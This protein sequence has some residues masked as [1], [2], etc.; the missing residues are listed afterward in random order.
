MFETVKNAQSFFVILN[1]VRGTAAPPPRPRRG[2]G[3][4]RAVA[5]AAAAAAAMPLSKYIILQ[6]CRCSITVMKE[7][8]LNL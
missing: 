3:R 1:G 5:A 6:A 2:R 4:G 8:A 7:L